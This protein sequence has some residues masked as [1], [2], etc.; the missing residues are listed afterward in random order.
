MGDVFDQAERGDVFDQAAAQPLRDFVANRPG[1]PRPT[2]PVNYVNPVPTENIPIVGPMIQPFAETYENLRRDPKFAMDTYRGAKA[3]A[4]AATAPLAVG[5]SI[6]QLV[7]GG[8][9]GTLGSVGGQKLAKVFDLGDTGQEI[10]GDV[11][12]LAGGVLGG[13]GADALAKNVS[14]NIGAKLKATGKILGQEAVSHVPFAGRIVRR[15]SAMDYLNAIM[16]KAP[17]PEPAYSKVRL[18]PDAPPPEIGLSKGLGGYVS[19]EPLASGL[20]KIPVAPDSMGLVKEIPTYQKL[21]I[22]TSRD[23]KMPP[24]R[25]PVPLEHPAAVQQARPFT[26]DT[27]EEAPH[28]PTSEWPP[29]SRI[30][31]TEPDSPSSPRRARDS[32]DSRADARTVRP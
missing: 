2:D 15:P 25:E 21:G 11:G 32:R 19:P 20:G 28:A 10:S 12:G 7:G 31:K 26:L 17:E 29:Q 27:P 24:V 22:K 14:P 8:I 16:A 23:F 3:G 9:G 4:M 13:M 30:F 6:P 18:G 1:V 5:A